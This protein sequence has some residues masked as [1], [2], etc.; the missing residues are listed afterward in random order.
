MMGQAS[1]AACG[2]A[3][4]SGSGVAA[5]YAAGVGLYESNPTYNVIGS[6]TRRGGSCS[7]S[8]SLSEAATL[9]MSLRMWASSICLLKR[10]EVFSQTYS[11]GL[12]VG[13]YTR[14]QL[15]K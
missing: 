7:L 9:V 1:M 4:L 11:C 12:V 14:S 10:E 15:L 13:S 8:L 2:S 3:A 6:L 5:L